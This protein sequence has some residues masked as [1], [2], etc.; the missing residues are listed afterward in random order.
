MIECD[1]PQVR[2]NP[3]KSPNVFARSALDST[4]PTNNHFNYFLAFWKLCRRMCRGEKQCIP[5]FVGFVTQMCIKESTK[6]VLTFLPPL[7]RPITEYSTVCET[8]YRSVK[9]AK[10]GNMKY[11]HITVDIGAAEKYYRVLWN[12]Q[13]EFKDV[14][15]HLGD[16]H[17][18]LH[19]F[20]NVRKFVSS[21][22]F[23]DILF[24]AGMCSY[25]S[26][27]KSLSGKAYNGGGS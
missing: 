11:T 21:S 23:K 24:Q 20:G 3:H 2:I 13:I 19:F 22:G 10:F 27:K 18:L 25:G 5:R 14:I 7:I 4:L 15:I 17:A 26:I 6:T 16:F 8:I 12:K 1:L 9:L